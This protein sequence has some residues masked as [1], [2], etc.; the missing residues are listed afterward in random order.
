MLES[1]EEYRPVP[2][3]WIVDRIRDL[4]EDLRARD[5][6]FDDLKPWRLLNPEP[7]Y[8]DVQRGDFD[9]AVRRICDKYGLAEER[10]VLHW[11]AKI[12]QDRV[13]AHVRCEQFGRVE[14]TI[15]DLYREDP[16]GF[17]TVI[18]HEIGHAYLSDMDIP[19]GGGWAEEATTD[20][21]T[22]VKGLGKLTVNGVDHLRGS[23]RAGSRCYGYLNREANVFAYAR[24]ARDYHVPSREMRASL[25]PAVL[26]YLNTLE[27]G[28]R[29]PP[30]CLFG[31]LLSWVRRPRRAADL[32]LT[33]DDEGNIVERRPPV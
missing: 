4:R 19:N 9:Q 10:I 5:R 23:E 3:D 33:V 15:R 7:V 27:G 17:G 25:N 11:V 13:A 14:I 29:E 16:L 30:G 28:Q 8:A 20:L 12:G 31:R 24:T 32:D 2:G 22:F 6:R 18:A 26:S 1:D 21:V